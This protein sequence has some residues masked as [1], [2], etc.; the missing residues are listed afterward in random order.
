MLPELDPRPPPAHGSVL[1]S[2]RHRAPS[3]AN[4]DADCQPADHRWRISGEQLTLEAPAFG[5]DAV[6]QRRLT[7]LHRRRCADTGRAGYSR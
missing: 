1:R 3:E 2:H 5:G 7:Q 6:A 4:V